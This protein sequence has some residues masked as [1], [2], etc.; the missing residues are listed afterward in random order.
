MMLLTSGRLK[1]FANFS[2]INKIGEI[3]FNVDDYTSFI[4]AENQGSW[5]PYILVAN[6]YMYIGYATSTRYGAQ[7]RLNHFDGIAVRFQNSGKWGE[8]LVL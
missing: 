1:F 4:P 6:N 8:W 2:A 7:L 3:N 5:M